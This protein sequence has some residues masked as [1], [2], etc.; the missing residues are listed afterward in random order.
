MYIK[1]HPVDTEY[2][3]GEKLLD[4]WQVDDKE[5]NDEAIPIKSILDRLDDEPITQN[6]EFEGG[7]KIDESTFGEENND[8]T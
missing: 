2:P 5:E 4:A 7:F 8:E 3:E 6:N 1:K